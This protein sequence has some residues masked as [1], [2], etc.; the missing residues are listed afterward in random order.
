MEKRNSVKAINIFTSLVYKFAEQ[1]GKGQ[2]LTPRTRSR[3]HQVGVE[4]GRLGSGERHGLHLDG[5]DDVNKK[6]QLS[7]T[8]P[9]DACEKFPRFT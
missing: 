2:A 8:N 5:Y 4:N 1:P 3:R 7:L 6:A 9:R